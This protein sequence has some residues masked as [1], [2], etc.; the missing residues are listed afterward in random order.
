MVKIT[1]TS[2]GYL[3]AITAVVGFGFTLIMLRLGSDDFGPVMMSVGRVFPLIIAAP[4]ILKLNGQRLWPAKEHFKYA[5]GSAI[6]VVLGYP[7]LSTIALQFIPA[8]DAGVLAA[9]GPLIT[10]SMAVLIGHKKPNR[11][12]WLAAGIGTAAAVA[13]AWVRGGGAFGGG[14]L[15]GYLIMLLA[16]PAT[17]LG[18]IAGGTLA[19]K[20]KALYAMCWAVMISIPLQL[21]ISVPWLILHP[22]TKMPSVT[23]WVAY[24][25]VSL[26]SI[27]FGNYLWNYGLS[28]IGIVHGSQLQLVQPI[29]T[30]LGAYL[31]LHE[32][33]HVETWL[34]A[35]VILAAVAWTQRLRSQPG[36]EVR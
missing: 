14:E 10:G 35:A 1:E 13:L 4:L 29:I 26:F 19:G 16:V 3:S 20:V 28:R 32:N 18:H 27:L 17:S 21:A 36:P 22:I 12:F 8:G 7:I 33:M 31:V 23:S 11:W 15:V 34:A 30:M 6:G 2:R 24:L 5:A 9:L 25:Y